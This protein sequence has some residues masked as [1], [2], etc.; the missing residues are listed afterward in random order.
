MAYYAP[1]TIIPSKLHLIQAKSAQSGI[2]RFLD[3]PGEI[4]NKI[5]DLVF[6]ECVVGVRMSNEPQFHDELID[7]PFV[8]YQRQSYNQYDKK[9]RPGAPQRAERQRGNKTIQP[10]SKAD[11]KPQKQATVAIQEQSCAVSQKSSNPQQRRRQ[12]YKKGPSRISHD[13]LSL[14]PS[15]GGNLAHY[16]IPFNLLFSSRQIYNE[17]LCVMYA[18][19]FFRIN[20]TKALNR[21][22]LI[23]PLRALQAIRGLGISHRTQGEPKLTEHRKFKIIDDKKWSTTCKQISEKM[24][25]LKTL[26]LDLEL[27]DWPC[28]LTLDEEWAQPILSLRQNGLE[29]VDATLSHTAF[30]QER[31]NAAARNLEVAMLSNEGRMAKFA[32]EKKLLE[33][34]KK[35]MESKP[36]RVLV[37]KMDNISST[38]KVQKA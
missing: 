36:R 12:H 9:R 5:Y 21:F 35:K 23:T 13:V 6:E 14:T 1:G 7:R 16:D 32:Q 8:H 30:I 33:A 4:R 27:H 25:D 34:R 11:T 10:S 37:I 15:G 22:L 31:L 18:K 28:H 24:T 38:P 26:R 29:R 3:L 17:A 20:S 19:T 2:F